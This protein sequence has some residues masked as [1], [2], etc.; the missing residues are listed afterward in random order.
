MNEYD[1]YLEEDED[2]VKII[3]SFPYQETGHGIVYRLSS[4]GLDVLL[5]QKINKPGT[6]KKDFCGTGGKRKKRDKTLDDCV[7]RE[8][9]EETG[10][11]CKVIKS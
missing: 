5:I 11:I 2:V 4:T 8:T 7:V 1:N 6:P 3:D 9:E 10:I